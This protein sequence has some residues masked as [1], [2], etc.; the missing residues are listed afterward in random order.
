MTTTTA[1]CPHCGAALTVAGL[2]RHESICYA[3][4]GLWERLRAAMERADRPGVAIS[5]DAYRDVAPVQGLPSYESL[6]RQL[7]GWAQ[8]C[9]WV[10]LQP[11]QRRGYAKGT[12][13]PPTGR[14]AEAESEVAAMLEA[15]AELRAAWDNRGLEVCRVRKLPGGDVAYVLR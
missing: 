5:S 8:I 3:R 15:D 13:R 9:N 1:T 2:A 6:T 11:G 7:G 12:R 14:G 4:P 10:G